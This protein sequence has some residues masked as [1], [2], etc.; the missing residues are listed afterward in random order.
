MDEEPSTSYGIKRSIPQELQDAVDEIATKLP[1][2]AG[3]CTKHLIS[4]LFSIYM[5]YILQ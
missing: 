5:T 1:R 2:K 3:M 4:T